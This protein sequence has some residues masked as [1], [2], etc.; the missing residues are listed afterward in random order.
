MFG[1]ALLAGCVRGEIMP[2]D[3]ESR[4][5]IKVLNSEN[6][7]KYAG[8]AYVPLGPGRGFPRAIDYFPEQAM[9]ER[10]GGRIEAM[11]SHDSVRVS[12]H[13]CVNPDS[14]LS[15]PP[16]IAVS[17]RSTRIDDAALRLAKDGD[18]KYRP[19]TLDGQPMADCGS[20]VVTWWTVH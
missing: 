12:V 10:D 16:T 15:E 13:V 14:K 20:F 3:K 8:H 18:G 7:A 2:Q 9:G 6:Q 5:E 19:A 11:R 4:E 17:S 1:V